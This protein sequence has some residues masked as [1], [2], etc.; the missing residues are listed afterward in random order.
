MRLLL[1]EGAQVNAQ[2]GRYGDALRAA[3]ARGH[4]AIVKLLLEKGALRSLLR[5]IPA[6]GLV[7]GLPLICI[8]G[9]APGYKSTGR[10]RIYD[11]K[12]TINTIDLPSCLYAPPVN[13]D[14]LS[15]AAI[16]P[17]CYYNIFTLCI[18]FSDVFSIF[19]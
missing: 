14:N 16:H 4:K 2:G 10:S 5:Y 15:N 3:R 1:K 18:S 7:A 9:G 19:L 8:K 12:T 6:K 11:S 17:T 13:L